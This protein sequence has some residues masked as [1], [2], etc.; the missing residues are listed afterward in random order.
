MGKNKMGKKSE[1]AKK[2]KTKAAND[3]PAKAT[4]KP[5]EAKAA[6]EKPTKATH[7]PVEAKVEASKSSTCVDATKEAEAQSNKAI[8][9]SSDAKQEDDAVSVVD[10][11]KEPWLDYPYH[12]DSS[13]SED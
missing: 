8:A 11:A 4:K 12:E 6:N 3:K 10:T 5:V 7:K 2:G 9:T 13:E 1:K